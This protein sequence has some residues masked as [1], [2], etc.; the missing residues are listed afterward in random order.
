[1]ISATLKRD[2]KLRAEGEA[3]RRARR[4]AEWENGMDK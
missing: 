4:G 2:R 3:G 1:M